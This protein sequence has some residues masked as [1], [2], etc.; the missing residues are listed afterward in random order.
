MLPDG[1]CGTEEPGRFAGAAASTGQ[2]GEALEDVGN[3]GAGLDICAGHEGVVDVAFGLFEFT[4]SSGHAGTGG[5]CQHV[6]PA[7]C[8]GDGFVGPAPGGDQ[9]TSC[10]RGLRHAFDIYR[11]LRTGELRDRLTRVAGGEN[12]AGGDGR[13][14]QRRAGGECRT[15]F[16][17]ESRPTKLVN[18]TERYAARP[19]VV[20]RNGGNSFTR[21][22]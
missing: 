10:K 12:I 22:G 9:V 7:R 19:A 20:A 2:I 13:N 14:T 16:I 18:C 21:S 11:P 5:Q 3:P 15:S 4:I 1:V 8:R 17:S 6:M